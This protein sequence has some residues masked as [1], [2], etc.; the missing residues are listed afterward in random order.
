MFSS[1]SVDRKDTFSSV[2]DNSAQI[3][4]YQRYGLIREYAARSALIPPF[5]LFVHIYLF[6]RWIWDCCCCKKHEEGGGVRLTTKLDEYEKEEMNEFESD[7][8]ASY[9]RSVRSQANDNTTENESVQE[10]LERV[11]H[12]TKICTTMEGRLKACED[13]N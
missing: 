6:L 8:V 5:I 13:K 4:K 11:K 2:K 3:W 12:L 7:S 1:S 9:V 10:L